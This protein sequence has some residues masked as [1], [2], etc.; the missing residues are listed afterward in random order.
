MNAKDEDPVFELLEAAHD[1]LEEGALDAAAATLERA[2]DT[3]TTAPELPYLEGSLALMRDRP[4]DAVKA[5]EAALAIDPNY[6]DA[7][8]LLAHAHERAGDDEAMIASFV[9]THALDAKADRALP[10][11]E[12]KAALDFIEGV[13]EHVLSRVPEPFRSRLENVPVILESQP[14]LELVEQGFDPRSFGL[15]EGPED[16][17]SRA[18]DVIPA[19]SRIVLFWANLLSEFPEEDVLAEEVEVTVLHEIGH[20]FGLDEEQVAALGL[21]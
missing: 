13:A 17:T 20:Y 15:F 19:P 2:R 10:K 11:S 3:G 8:H 18:L 6:A 1:Q 12:V 7:H 9:R 16:A 4:E 21:A 5:L 14:P